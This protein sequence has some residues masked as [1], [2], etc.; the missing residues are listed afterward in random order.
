M[1]ERESLASS[2][3]YAGGIKKCNYF[4]APCIVRQP[5]SEDTEDLDFA[6]SFDT[7]FQR[8]A[9]MFMERALMSAGA[10]QS[11]LS[12][13]LII[14]SLSGREAGSGSHPKVSMKSY[15]VVGL[16]VLFATTAIAQGQHDRSF[17]QAIVGNQY[18]VPKNESADRL[19]N[20]LSSLLASPDPEL[21]DDLAYSILARWI[22]RG[23]LTQPTLIF[24]TDT[25]QQNLKI[26]LGETGTNSVLMRS[27]SALCLASVA[28]REARTPFMGSERYHRLVAEAISYLQAERDLRGYDTKLHWIHAT[29]HTADLL[30][31]LA[32]GT[33]LTQDEESGI[34]LAI[35]TRL[36]TAPE[37]FT[38]GEQD[39]LAAAVVAV[40][41]RS[42]FELPKFEQWLTALQNEDRDVWAKTSPEALARYQNHTYFL[43]ALYVRLA[44]EPD[45]SRL[46]E[47]RKSTLAAMKSRLD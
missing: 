5:F 47:F 16:F 22:Y 42:D 36:T 2:S 10:A 7:A 19:A 41:R 4:V 40:I 34:L 46:G 23:L 21:R 1:S 26:S 9:L 45:S 38:Q 28:R 8:G 39:R 43:Q 25:W 11:N 6:D 20:E 15:S 12:S 13:I 17:W 44:T 35:S 18:L 31:G 3:S 30:A 33:Q 29:A 24:L 32:G 37:V 27:F 14:S